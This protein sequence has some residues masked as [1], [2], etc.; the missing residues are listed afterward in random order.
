MV[1]GI[2]DLGCAHT[3][4]SLLG[5]WGMG[6]MVAVV[7]AELLGIGVAGTWFEDCNILC[8]IIKFEY[9]ILKNWILIK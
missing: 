5:I 8:Q 3:L 2:E 9:N 4:V 1:G 6:L 7:V